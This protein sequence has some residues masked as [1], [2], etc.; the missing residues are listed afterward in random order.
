MDLIPEDH[1]LESDTIEGNENGNL[2]DTRNQDCLN[3][4]ELTRSL[5][6]LPAPQSTADLNLI[7][8]TQKAMNSHLVRLNPLLFI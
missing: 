6:P 1:E 5:R 7:I 4:R 3:G 8:L 2:K